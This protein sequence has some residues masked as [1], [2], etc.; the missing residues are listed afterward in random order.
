MRTR[1]HWNRAELIMIRK[2]FGAS[3]R[4]LKAR[5][6]V[7]IGLGP[8]AA[9]CNHNAVSPLLLFA[10]AILIPSFALSA[11][12]QTP[13]RIERELVNHVRSIGRLAAENTGEAAARL[14]AENDALKAK[15]VKYGRL[16]SVLKHPFSDLKK[17]MYIA[18]SRDGKFRIFSWD[19]RTGGTMHFFENVFQYQGAGGKIVAKA[20]VLDDGDP[21]GFYHDIFQVAGKRGPVY[22]GRLTSVLS[23]RDSYEE[24]CLFRVSGTR[25]DDELR[26]FKTKAGMQNRIGYEYDFFSVV[27]RKERPIKL[28]RFDEKTGTIMIPVVIADKASDGPGRVTDR[29]IK[30]RFNGTNFVLTR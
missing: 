2:I 7:L 27:D 16:A 25:L 4:V 12:A 6:L 21:G 24:V 23:T 15:L 8:R 5:F 20:A 29:F 26:L 14:D 1:N 13:A 18:T 30:Y 22:I 10:A 11:V 17:V 3:P 19:T 28:A 9:G